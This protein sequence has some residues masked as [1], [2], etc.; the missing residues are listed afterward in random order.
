MNY[1]PNMLPYM[2]P[3][4]FQQPQMPMM[5]IPIQNIPMMPYYNN[6]PSMP[7]QQ[8]SQDS[9]DTLFN[10]QLLSQSQQPISTI[11]PSSLP[12]SEPPQQQEEKPDPFGN[13]LDLM[14]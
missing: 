10:P 2:N 13:L 6:P 8:F 5:Q 11:P 14:K 3:M 7:P 12:N 9:Y 4:Q 1:P